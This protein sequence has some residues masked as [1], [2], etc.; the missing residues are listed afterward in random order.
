MIAS[1]PLLRGNLAVNSILAAEPSSSLLEVPS[2]FYYS[3]IS[4]K[5]LSSIDFFSP[6]HTTFAV[7]SHLAV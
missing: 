2:L 4:P 3:Y 6:V 7:L 1:K 5:Q